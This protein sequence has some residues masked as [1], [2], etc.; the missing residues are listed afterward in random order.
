M[1]VPRSNQFG[2]EQIRPG[3]KAFFDAEALAIKVCIRQR[4]SSTSNI[5]IFLLID[6][7]D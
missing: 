6:L 2:N 4:P 3:G 5:E 1:T 7:V